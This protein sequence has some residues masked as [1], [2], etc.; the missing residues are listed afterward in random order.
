MTLFLL[1]KIHT[2]MY[3]H[4]T[5][6]YPVHVRVSSYDM[7]VR[8]RCWVMVV[9]LVRVGEGS[10]R[11]AWRHTVHLAQGVWLNTCTLIIE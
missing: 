9:R 4:V 3:M 7:E 10:S 1:L 6:A 8:M 2:Y 11:V 5:L